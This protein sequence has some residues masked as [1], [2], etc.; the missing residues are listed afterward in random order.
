M[1][2]EVAKATNNVGLDL[3]ESVKKQLDSVFA[4]ELRFR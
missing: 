3:D 2:A 1:A 4:L